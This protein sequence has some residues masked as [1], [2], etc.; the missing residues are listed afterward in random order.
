M[1]DIVLIGEQLAEQSLAEVGHGL[2]VIHIAGSE[3]EAD[4]LTLGVDNGVE[5]ESIEPT[6]RGLATLGAVC[7]DSMAGDAPVITNS[8]RGGVGNGNPVALAFE[9]LEQGCQGSCTA[10]QEFHTSLIARQLRKLSPQVAAHVDQVKTLELAK[11]Q[12]ME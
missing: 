12:L 9:Y 6:H 10:G 3:L 8:D 1:G 2:T 7:E 4:Q 11:A 5:L